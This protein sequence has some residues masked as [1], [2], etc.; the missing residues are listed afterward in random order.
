MRGISGEGRLTGN[1]IDSVGFETGFIYDRYG[2]RSVLYPNSDSTDVW[3]TAPDGLMVGDWSDVAGNIYGYSLRAGQFRSLN[4]PGAASVTSIRGINAQ[5]IMVG[6]F[7]DAT[8]ALHGFARTADGHYIQLDAPGAAVTFTNRIN[9]QD[10]IV[11][12]YQ[13]TDGAA[14]G[15]LLTGWQQLPR[16]AAPAGGS[17]LQGARAFLD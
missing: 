7:D 3:D 2:F 13:G 14:H 1:Y 17:H 6:V 8:G 9:N 5:H 16:I 10:A 4:V 15:Y 11:G 12:F